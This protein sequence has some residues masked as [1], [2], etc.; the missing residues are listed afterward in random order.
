MVSSKRIL[1][2]FAVCKA[3]TSRIQ[4]IV[5]PFLQGVLTFFIN[6]DEKLDGD[7]RMLGYILL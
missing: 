6:T 7:V 3:V 1:C 5:K 2:L 4:G